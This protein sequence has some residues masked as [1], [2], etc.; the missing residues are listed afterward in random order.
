MLWYDN[1]TL[2]CRAGL[3]KIP[4]RNKSKII[5]TGKAILR[6]VPGYG[7]KMETESCRICNLV[8]SEAY[9]GS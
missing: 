9:L 4:S 6:E 2:G 8:L 3:T 5:I 1:D 7:I